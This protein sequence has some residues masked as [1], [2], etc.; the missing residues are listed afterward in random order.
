MN[1][2]KTWFE[3]W[4]DTPFYHKLYDHRNEEEAKLF[5][6]NLINFLQLKRGDKILDLP[7]GKGRHAV[8]LN[9]LGFNV[10]GADLSS[11][12]IEYAKINENDSLSFQI[13]DMRKE[14]QNKYNAIFNLFTSFGYFEE[15]E[16]NIKVLQNFKNGL[17]NN[18]VIVLDFLNIEKAVNNMVAEELIDKKG[19]HFHIKRKLTDNF[20][21]K[22]I[23]FTFEGENYQ[24]E[25]KV[26][27]LTLDNF[28]MMANKAGLSIKNVFGDYHLKPFDR[29]KS[30]RL[31]LIFK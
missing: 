20:I 19:I 22:E 5:I 7:C 14:L 25:E 16:I 26:Q 17:K 23:R 18:G 9:K 3:K 24:F 13:H 15:D 30:D 2:K 27:C 31:I 4:F 28:R 1:N 6:D 10:L 21:I 12:S 11:K 8:Y 29:E